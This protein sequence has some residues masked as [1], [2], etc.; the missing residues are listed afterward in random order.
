MLRNLAYIFPVLLLIF[1]CSETNEVG[2]LEITKASIGNIPLPFDGSI[3][4][5]APVD[6]GINMIFNQPINETTPPEVVFTN[7]QGNVNTLLNFSREN[8]SLTIRPIGALTN[9]ET[10]TL[11]IS[12]IISAFGR[13]IESLEFQFTTVMGDLRIISVRSEEKEITAFNSV[14]DV[15]VRLDFEIDFSTAVSLDQ[16]EEHTLIVGKEIPRI[17]LTQ[18]ND[19]KTVQIR[20]LTRLDNISSYRL[21]I[22]NEL[23]GMEGEPFDGFELNFFTEIDSTVKFPILSDDALLTLVQRQTFRYFWDFAHP[24]SGLSRERNTSN[25]TVTMGGSGFGVMS[26][27]VGIE[28]GFITRIQGVERLNLITTFLELNAERF[29]GA[30]S[31]WL[32]GTTGEAIPFSAEDDAAD[33]VETAFMIQALITARQ[34][35]NPSNEQEAAIISRINRLCNDVE[36]DWFT[37]NNQ[38]VLYWHWSPNFNWNMDMPVRGWN[39]CLITYI[40]AASSKTYSISPEVY[41]S[42][43]ARNGNMR[44]NGNT[45]YGYKLPLRSDHGGPLFF[46]HYSFM[47]LDPRNLNDKYADYWEQNRLHT[48]IN[49][50]YCAANPQRY[51]G[52]SDQC[53]GLTASDGNQGYSAHSPDNDRGVITPTAALSSMPYTPEYSMEAL[54]FFYYILG[55]KLWGKY[56]FYD[57]FNLTEGWFARSYIAIDQ[58]PIICMIENYR[59]GLLWNLFMS[60]PEIQEGL[61]KLGFT[62]E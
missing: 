20:A 18:L 54:R 32:N 45:Y 28:R 51:V 10:Y 31:H 56:G 16:L 7:T 60:A 49:R 37:R 58:G 30:W 5:D 38:N 36:W 44:N 15:P 50:A 43:W 23:K 13:Q 59:T 61:D 53:W 33:L 14:L 46:A 3:L 42:G 12:N 9:G 24:V 26:I 1:S 34:Y 19:N 27:L 6:R 22:S 17:R 8:Q 39:E 48:L 55:D 21:A 35:L 2:P 41:E 62:Y 47:G 11:R 52:Y 57:A 40:L 4:S 25:E 29:H